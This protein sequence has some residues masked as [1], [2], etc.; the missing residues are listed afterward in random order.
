MPLTSLGIASDVMVLGADSTLE[1]HPDRFILRSPQ[2]PDY[3]FG[4]MVILRDDVIDPDAQ[5]A[6]FKADFPKAT[7]V[8][9]SWDIVGMASDTRVDVYVAQGFKV[10]RADVLTLDR[11]L[12]R[13]ETPKDISI[14]PLETDLDWAKA[15]ELQAITGVA[16]GNHADEY[17]PFIK[18][19]MQTC[20]RLT[21]EGRGVWFGAFDGDRLAGDLGIYA[22]PR[23]ARFQAVETR[24]RDRRRGICAALV[25]AGVEWAKARHPMTCPIIIATKNG[26]AGRVYRRCGFEMKEQLLAVYRGPKD[27]ETALG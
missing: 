18:T 2:E 14:R 24:E 27:A 23:T 22:D 20:R 3:W 17:L 19:R 1:V 6:Q 16:E 11:E 13:T 7:H 15:T 21:Q 4:N 26:D 12:V 9:I 8:T 10:D 25:T 5:I